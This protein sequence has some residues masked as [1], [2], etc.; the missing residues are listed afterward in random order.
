[1]PHRISLAL[2]VCNEVN[3][4]TMAIEP[5]IN[6]EFND[7]ELVVT[8]NAS[9]DANEQIYGASAASDKR[10][11]YFRNE[12]NLGAVANFNLRYSLTSGDYFERCSHDDL[13]NLDFPRPCADIAE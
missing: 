3:T 1:M 7:F 5:I 4:I 11:R 10:M 2:P 9:I 13:L 6:H 12:R 8:D